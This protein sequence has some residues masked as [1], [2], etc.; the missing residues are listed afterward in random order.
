MSDMFDYTSRVNTQIIKDLIWLV[1]STPL[2]NM[3]F[4]M[5]S[6]SPKFGVRIKPI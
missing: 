2:K 4:K 6:S 5:G 1:V 3:L